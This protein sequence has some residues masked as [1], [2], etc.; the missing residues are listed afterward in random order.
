MLIVAQPEV[1]KLENFRIT[2]QGRLLSA[3]FCEDSN[4]R[5]KFTNTKAHS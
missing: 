5:I 1:T 2:K 4:F 3:Q